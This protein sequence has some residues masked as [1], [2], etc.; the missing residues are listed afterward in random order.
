MAGVMDDRSRDGARYLG[1][2]GRGAWAI[3]ALFVVTQWVL[4]YSANWQIANE[5]ADVVALFTLT[6]LAVIMV[7]PGRYPV[8]RS[9]AAIAVAG[10]AAITALVNSVLPSHGWPGYSSWQFG[11]NTFVLMALALRGR[12]LWAWL[13]MFVMAAL[14]IGWTVSSG[15]G[16][17]AGIDLVDRNAATLL[18]GTFFALGIKRSIRSMNSFNET[19][20][21]QAADEASAR[22]ALRE[23]NEA[24]SQLESSAMVALRD[25]A[26]ERALSSSERRRLLSMEAMLR[27]RIRATSLAREPLLSAVAR[28]RERG[29][30]VL[31]L[32][33]VGTD[34]NGDDDRSALLSWAAAHLDEH[35][36]ASTVI[37]L[38][39]D[40]QSAAVLAIVDDAGAPVEMVVAVHH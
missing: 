33:D 5:P 13:G 29:A 18:I 17:L 2:T 24:L 38:S 26:A 35:H 40:A 39:R 27:D 32:D 28:A 37:R 12:N 22:A 10:V 15:D 14:T 8:P 20:A 30:E 6:G 3:A 19:I 9:W 34:P 25:I 1:L 36:V 16:V 4:A 23:R 21:R 11:A 31:L 7:V